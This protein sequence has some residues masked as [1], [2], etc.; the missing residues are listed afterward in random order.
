MGL[1]DKMVGTQLT[2]NNGITCSTTMRV[3]QEPNVK[4]IEYNNEK[5]DPGTSRSKGKTTTY[6][7]TGGNLGQSMS[8]QLRKQFKFKV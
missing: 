1:N 3:E 8:D 6:E 7:S 5:F 2:G 4:R